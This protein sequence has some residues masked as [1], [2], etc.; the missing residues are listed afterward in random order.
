MN[1]IELPDLRINLCKP[2]TF[3][4]SQL[5]KPNTSSFGDGI[6]YFDWNGERCHKVGYKQHEHACTVKEKILYVQPHITSNEQ[7][8]M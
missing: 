1:K 4:V 7:V 5:L 8:N 6:L 3:F 2:A